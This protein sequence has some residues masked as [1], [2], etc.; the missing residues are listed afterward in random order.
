MASPIM[1]YGGGENDFCPDGYEVNWCGIIM[2][3]IVGILLIY[4][5]CG[6][7]E[8]YAS[9]LI[10]KESSERMCKLKKER[11]EINL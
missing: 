6:R 1:T 10:N 9:G 11:Y 8:N 5:I 7:Q 3:V 2:W 4:F